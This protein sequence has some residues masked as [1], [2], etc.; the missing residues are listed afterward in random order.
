MV[1]ILIVVCIILFAGMG[2]TVWMLMEK[3]SGTATAQSNS[4]ENQSMQNTSGANN[5]SKVNAH[6]ASKNASVM[7]AKDAKS[8]MQLL[9]NSNNGK[10]CSISYPELN[11]QKTTYHAV[12]YGMD[13]NY[14][15]D[16]YINS[17]TGKLVK[18]HWLH[19]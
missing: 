15:G 4:I 8:H 11:S 6:I 13:G 16:I 2:L 17:K 14:I 12:I 10:G 19:D 5:N 9:V 1:K 18:L 7:S 3:N